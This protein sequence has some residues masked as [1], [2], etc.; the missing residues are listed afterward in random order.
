MPLTT[1]LTIEVPFTRALGAWMAD[2][3]DLGSPPRSAN[4]LRLGSGSL[5]NP[6]QF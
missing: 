4:V 5:S 3:T 6:V 2:A 1:A